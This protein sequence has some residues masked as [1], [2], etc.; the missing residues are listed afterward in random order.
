M[1]S[2]STSDIKHE[3]RKSV[4][5]ITGI[6]II[7]SLITVSVITSVTI[8]ASTYQEWNNPEKWLDYP[9]TSI[10]IWVNYFTAEKTPEHK[11]ITPNTYES[12]S[13]NIHLVSQQF[14]VNFDYDDF[15]SDF[16]YEFQTRYSDSSLVSINLLRP[17]GVETVSYTHL[18]LPTNREV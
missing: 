7:F 13:D 14:F 5:G 10:P 15:P 8:P 17:D 4:L 1:S 3:F 9:K 6:I 16:V 18:T 11:I 2:L 12:N